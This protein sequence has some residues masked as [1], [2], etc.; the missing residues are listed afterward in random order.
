MNK[1]QKK[2]MIQKQ[3]KKL[4]ERYPFLLP[5]NRWTDKVV[6]NY[7]Y[8]YTE[9]D[10]M[11][12]GWK[13]AFGVILCEELR[14]SLL[15]NGFLEKYRIT[16]IKEK[17][18]GLRWYSN[19]CDEKMKDI[20]NKYEY[21][22]EHICI[23]CGKFDVSMFDDGWVSPYCDNCFI[24]KRRKI[25]KNYQKFSKKELPEFNEKELLEKFRL[26]DEPIETSLHIETMGR[27]GCKH[28]DIDLSNIINKLRK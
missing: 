7:N 27:D 12:R 10:A 14:E 17:Y 9:L 15:E 11:P 4:I 24:E 22:S 28:R 1:R 6:K 25:N 21:L 2:K 26:E 3:N 19:G 5:R 20:I 18:G 8:T 16:Q 23:E 13:K